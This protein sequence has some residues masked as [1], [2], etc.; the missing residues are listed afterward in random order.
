M[1]ATQCYSVA[2][3]TYKVKCWSIFSSTIQVVRM[4]L[5][6]NLN[7]MKTRVH[8]KFSVNGPSISSLFLFGYSTLK[9][10][11]KYVNLNFS[12][13]ASMSNKTKNV[14]NYFMA[15]EASIF[16]VNCLH[17]KNYSKDQMFKY[18]MDNVN[19]NWNSRFHN[20]FMFRTR[21]NVNSQQWQCQTN[22][23]LTTDQFN[24]LL[25]SIGYLCSAFSL[26]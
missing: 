13:G 23:S 11:N 20:S 8:F 1:I 18:S 6:L 21:K 24:N 12:S 2:I 22:S 5:H 19:R 10:L 25:Y 9:P 16:A 15:F 7:D 26:G 3:S 17:F 4:L 14:N